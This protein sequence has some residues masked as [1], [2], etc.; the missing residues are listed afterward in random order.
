MVYLN[1]IEIGMNANRKKFLK[2]I[3]RS[4]IGQE[5]E[6]LRPI[7][8]GTKADISWNDV[9]YYLDFLLENEADA[10]DHCYRYMGLTESQYRYLVNAVNEAHSL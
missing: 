4:K 10:R 8:D 2:R 7:E 1:E 9:V 5:L 6:F 3:S